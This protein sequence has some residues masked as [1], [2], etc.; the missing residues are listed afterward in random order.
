M[1]PKK[2]K[3]K[4]SRSYEQGIAF[5]QSEIGVAREEDIAPAGRGGKR[6][7]I[8]QLGATRSLPKNKTDQ[9]KDR[10]Q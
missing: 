2:S 8:T 10:G 6:S 7:F 5:V 9:E 3:K 4:S 1:N